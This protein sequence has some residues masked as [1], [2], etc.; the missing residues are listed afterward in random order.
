M[1]W[2]PLPPQFHPI[3]R[4]FIGQ[5]KY[6]STKPQHGGIQHAIYPVRVSGF[7]INAGHGV[8]ELSFTYPAENFEGIFPPDFLGA[9]IYRGDQFIATFEFTSQNGMLVTTLD[10]NDFLFPGKA[11]FLGFG[12]PKPA[13][14]D[15]RRYGPVI[16]DVLGWINSWLKSFSTP[17][18][19]GGRL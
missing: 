8:P 18:D 15:A 2:V 3:D 4:A 10:P 12:T 19:P 13:G 9:L 5:I 17:Q 11:G 6:T 16:A 14:N 7:E 1:P